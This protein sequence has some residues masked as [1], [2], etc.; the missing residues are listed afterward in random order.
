MS[1]DNMPY[2]PRGAVEHRIDSCFILALD[3][4]VLNATPRSLCPRERASLPVVE[5]AGWIPGSI[6]TGME[7][8]KSLAPTGFRT[9]TRPVCS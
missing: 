5:G 7:K 6:W 2:R 8:S 1:S 3:G 9:R 4:W